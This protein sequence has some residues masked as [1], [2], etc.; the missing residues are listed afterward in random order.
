MTTIPEPNA[1][2]DHQAAVAA[3]AEKGPALP[4]RHE[5]KVII[6]LAHYVPGTLAGLAAFITRE[7]NVSFA[8][9]ASVESPLRDTRVTKVEVSL[10]R[11]IPK[12]PNA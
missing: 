8:E 12:D 11:P 6:T 5:T 7:L 1:H 10:A 9:E 3:K 4:P 2:L